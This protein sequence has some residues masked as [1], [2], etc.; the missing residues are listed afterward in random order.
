[1]LYCGP[2]SL[3]ASKFERNK[4]DGTNIREFDQQQ[5]DN[6]IDGLRYS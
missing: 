4:G 2:K 5:S 3:V 6:K 1:M